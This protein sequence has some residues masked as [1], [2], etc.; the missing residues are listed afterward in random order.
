MPS[1]ENLWT[2]DWKKFPK[3]FHYCQVLLYLFHLFSYLHENKAAKSYLQLDSYIFWTTKGGI[4]RATSRALTLIPKT[5]RTEK[6]EQALT[7][8]TYRHVRYGCDYDYD[9]AAQHTDQRV[10]IE[11]YCLIC[12][13]SDVVNATSDSILFKRINFQFFL[14]IFEFCIDC[15]SCRDWKTTTMVSAYECART[16]CKRTVPITTSREDAHSQL[17]FWSVEAQRHSRIV[18]AKPASASTS[19]TNRYETKRRENMLCCEHTSRRSRCVYDT[20][21]RLLAHVFVCVCVFGV[22]NRKCM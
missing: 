12:S 3:I 5:V 1:I 19:R 18:Y 6:Q 2:E 21:T 4:V 9:C 10:H 13:K 14:R 17:L 15:M 7:K 8:Y 20:H 11:K 16:L 22:E